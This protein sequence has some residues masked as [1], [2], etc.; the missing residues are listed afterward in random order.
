MYQTWIIWN[1]ELTYHCHHSRE[2]NSACLEIPPHKILSIQRLLHRLSDRSLYGPARKDLNTYSAQEYLKCTWK[3]WKI[4]IINLRVYP[5]TLYWPQMPASQS[6][7][8]QSKVLNEWASHH[9]R[10]DMGPHNAEV[11]VEVQVDSGQRDHLSAYAHSK[12]DDYH[13]GRERRFD[14]HISHSI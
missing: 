4:T 2:Q 5:Y 12:T 7:V 6:F 8:R 10:K 13:T 1:E 11:Q 3:Y 14:A 9:R